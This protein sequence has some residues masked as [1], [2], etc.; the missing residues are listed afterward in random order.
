M[1]KIRVYHGSYCEVC[2][3][4]LDNYFP[5]CFKHE[6][7]FLSIFTSVISYF[8]YELYHIWK[9]IQLKNFVEL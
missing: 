6:N 1:N 9:N 3:P 8:F 4:S 7:P 2:N 5:Y